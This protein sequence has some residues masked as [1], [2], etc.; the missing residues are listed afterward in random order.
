MHWEH[1]TLST[2]LTFDEKIQVPEV[3][4]KIV[5]ENEGKWG[6]IAKHQVKTVFNPSSDL[7]K[8]QA[9]M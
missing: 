1:A 3:R 9:K 8:Q 2:L 5:Q 7:M 6:A 4:E